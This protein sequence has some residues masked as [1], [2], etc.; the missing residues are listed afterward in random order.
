MQT[1]VLRLSSEGID[2]F[3][4]GKLLLSVKSLKY[5]NIIKRTAAKKYFNST[6]PYL[7]Y[8]KL[9]QIKLFCDNLI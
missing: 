3:F 9:V 5:R 1:A 7:Q 8:I 4:P 6:D 2:S